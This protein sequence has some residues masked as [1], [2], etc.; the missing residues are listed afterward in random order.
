MCSTIFGEHNGCSR[1]LKGNAFV[2]RRNGLDICDFCG[3]SRDQVDN[4]MLGGP[5]R[6]VAI[7]N[8][9]VEICIEVFNSPPTDELP[10]PDV[11]SSPTPG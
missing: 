1:V 10:G 9:C 7:C 11:S 6:G 2:S 3:K 5:D 4:L 8:E